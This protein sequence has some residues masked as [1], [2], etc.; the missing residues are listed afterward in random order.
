MSYPK[1]MYRITPYNKIIPV[2]VYG[3]IGAGANKR[4]YIDPDTGT[5]R[6]HVKA[7]D[8]ALTPKAA[9]KK[10]DRKLARQVDRYEALLNGAKVVRHDCVRNAER[11]FGVFISEPNDDGM[12]YS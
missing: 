4:F 1:K 10:L 11:K 7:S 5:W 3:S 12:P 8:L 6:K 2:K 9:I